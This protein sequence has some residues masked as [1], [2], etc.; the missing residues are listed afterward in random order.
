MQAHNDVSL[1]NH[2]T[3]WFVFRVCVL[4][5]VSEACS[6]EKAAKASGKFGGVA[7]VLAGVTSL[8][9]KEKFVKLLR[10]LTQIHT[11]NLQDESYLLCCVESA[12]E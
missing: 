4:G 2:L 5:L 8:K 7:G 11:D 6:L 1:V 10:A 9:E 3:G 12:R